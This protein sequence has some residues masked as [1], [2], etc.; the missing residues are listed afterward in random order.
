VFLGSARIASRN[1]R[2]LAQAVPFAV[3]EQLAEDPESLHFAV[4]R[5]D[6]VGEVGVAAISRRTLTDL[7]NELAEHGLVAV[8]AVPD[9]LLLPWQEGQ[10][11]VLLEAGRALVRYGDHAAAALEA[12]TIDSWLGLLLNNLAGR[13]DKIVVYA[14]DHSVAAIDWPLPSENAAAENTTS[15]LL[16]TGLARTDFNLLQADFAPQLSQDQAPR[17]QWPALAASAA[18]LLA[19]VVNFTELQN[20][21][22]SSERLDQAIESRFHE[23]FPQVQRL[24]DPIIQAERELQRLR[25]GPAAARDDFVRLLSGVTATI[26]ARP[27]LT[28]TSLRYRNRQMQLELEA[29]SIDELEQLQQVAETAGLTATLQSARLGADGVSGT[30]TLTGESS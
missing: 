2:Q 9:A 16:A 19:L 10:I 28:L 27:G 8:R 30:L 18:V 6:P 23:A 13:P 22:S 25:G 29:A 21:K 20:L 17:W 11:S 4:N 5:G 3:E 12:D 7:L 26:S 14:S 15:A 1:A 24:Q